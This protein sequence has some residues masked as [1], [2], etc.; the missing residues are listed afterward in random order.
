MVMAQHFLDLKDGTSIFQDV[1]GIG[2]PEPVGCGL[3]TG[4]F[5]EPTELQADCGGGDR[6]V[7]LFDCKKQ[8]SLVAVGP[9]PDDIGNNGLEGLFG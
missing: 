2:M 9:G 7:W 3:K 4:L 1:L 6:L 5:H 8:S